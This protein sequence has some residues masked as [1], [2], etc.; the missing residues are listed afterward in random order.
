M[1]A[2]GSPIET[3]VILGGGTAGWMAAAAL[4]RALQN[5]DVRI[6]VIESDEIGTI[7]VGEAT[8]PAIHQFNRLLGLDQAD[9]MRRCQATIKLGIEFVDW[10]GLG[11]RYMHPF[12]PY[13]AG[14]PHFHRL[15]LKHA[16][17]GGTDRID[18]YNLGALAARAGRFAAGDGGRSGVGPLNYAFHFDAALYAKYLRDYAEQRGVV[19]TQGKAVA[20]RQDGGT[21]HIKAICLDSGEEIA[22]DFFIDC[23]GFGGF[24]IEQTLHTGYDAWSDVLPCDRAIAVQCEGGEIPVPYTRSTADTAGWMWRIPLQNRIGNGYVYSSAH[25]GDD[26]AEARL[27]AQLDGAATTAPRRLR[28]V[29]GKR[30]RVWNGNCLALGLAAGFLEPLE[31]TSIHLIQTSI[32][33]LL[34]LFP[35]KGFEPVEIAEFNRQ[36]DEE[37]DNIRDFLIAHYKL[38]QRDDT[39][40]WRHCRDMVVPERVQAIIDLFAAKGRLTMRPEHLFTTQSW[41]AVLLGQGPLPRDDDPLLKPMPE[42]EVVA[43]MVQTRRRLDQAVAAMP[44]HE[45][46]LRGLGQGR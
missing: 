46:F 22:G 21:G 17:A 14:Q 24:L 7:G 1:N 37:Y 45:D 12:T 16:H 26:E 38:T 4:S 13:G 10:G 42:D 9:F 29:T 36:T 11:R 32:L 27:L 5:L 20:A 31:S 25:I 23:S 28:F 30:K 41:L 15:W 43:Q 18:A 40:F 6:R 3:I 8:V 2:S 34:S 39:A 35:D 33:R 44:S 19:R